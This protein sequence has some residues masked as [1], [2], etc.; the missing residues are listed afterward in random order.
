MSILNPCSKLRFP[1]PGRSSEWRKS[2]PIIWKEEVRLMS[3]RQI[4]RW[5]YPLFVVLLSYLFLGRLHRTL[6]EEDGCI[7]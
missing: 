5:F 1:A 6:K 4:P 7:F 2:I 3:W